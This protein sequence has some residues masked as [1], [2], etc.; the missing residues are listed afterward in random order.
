[1]AGF[2]LAASIG[3]GM[4]CHNY[5]ASLAKAFHGEQHLDDFFNPYYMAPEH[6][7]WSLIQKVKKVAGENEIPV[8]LSFNAEP[9]VIMLYS[10]MAGIKTINWIFDRP[11]YKLASLSYGTWIVCK[12]NE[13]DGIK[14]R[15]GIKTKP[16]FQN[17]V[18]SAFQIVNQVQ[19]LK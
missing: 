6:K 1:M 10:R 14:K 7:P 11:R 8:F 9:C 19:Q 13:I 2:L 12:K 17:G 18:Y 5:R 16:L 4:F 15:F 3:W